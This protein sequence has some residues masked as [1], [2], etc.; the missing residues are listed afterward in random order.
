MR[1]TGPYA[2]LLEQRFAAACARIGLRPSGR[3][4]C[5]RICF[6]VPPAAGDQL[7]LF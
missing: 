6:R 2:A 1:G 3:S 5:A 7:P 4:S